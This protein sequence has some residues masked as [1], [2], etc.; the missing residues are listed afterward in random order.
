MLDTLRSSVT[1][2]RRCT[3]RFS[4]CLIRGVAFWTADDGFWLAFFTGLDGSY[5]RWFDDD[6]CV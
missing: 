3:A 1:E 2:T 5:L 4:E 6:G